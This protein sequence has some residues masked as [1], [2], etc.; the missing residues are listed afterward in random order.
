MKY[1]YLLHG[2][3]NNKYSKIIDNIRNYSHKKFKKYLNNSDFNYGYPHI[4]IIYGPVLYNN[5]IPL[6]IFDEKIINDFYP[7]FIKKFNKLPSDLKFI[8]VTPFF[9]IDKITIKAEFESK[10]LNNMRKFLIENN[11]LIKS[12]YEEFKKNK[13]ET[14]PILK[15]MFPNIFIKDKS[16]NKIPK[17]WIHSTILVINSDVSENNILN[18]IKNIETKLEKKIK[19]GDILELSEIGINLKNKFIKIF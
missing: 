13:N 1:K 19:K 9:S 5:Y 3:F 6:D 15:K 2:H 11:P 4:T 7:G 16:Y 14:E 12:Y 10:Q 17:G 18:I 8:G